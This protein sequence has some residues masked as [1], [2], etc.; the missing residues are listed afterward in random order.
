VKIAM[1]SNRDEALRCLRLAEKFLQ[2]GE[3]EKAAKFGLKA[4][5]LFPSGE[6]EEFLA[7]VANSS[8][9]SNL[10]QETNQQTD[11][12]Q[13][14]GNSQSNSS[15][16]NG[17]STSAGKEYTSEQVEAVKRVRK[18]QDYYEILGVTKEASESDLKKSYQKLALQ[19]HPDKNHAPGAGEAF[20]AIGNAF[21]VLSDTEK[22][23]QYDLYGPMEERTSRP[24]R[25]RHGFYEHDPTHGF[26]SDMTA[27]EIFN[28]FFGGTGFPSQS[29][30][31]RRGRNTAHFHRHFHNSHG[32]HSETTVREPSGFA[33]LIQLMPILIVIFLSVISSLLVSDP[34]YS[35]Q[36]TTKYHIRRTTT[37]LH[38]PYFVKDSFKNDFTG[39]L[40]KLESN[41]EEEYLNS[42]RQACYRE[43][44]YKEN[45]LW[46]AR[47]SGNS[48]LLNRAHNYAT[49]SCDQLERIYTY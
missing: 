39:S 32:H 21:A 36:A 9:K 6:A 23:R 26:E 7:K 47:Y 41:I 4:K 25:G 48:N 8:S 24:S 38:I 13:M 34:H 30:Y 16:S 11:H 27:E 17:E 14:N 18:C 3:K 29:V 44:S 31:V 12:S 43:K 19:F 33:A 37:N 49:P 46:Q 20:K 1:E 22:R 5:K 35:L 28:M 40:R 15:S 10:N 2:Q 42:L 45:L